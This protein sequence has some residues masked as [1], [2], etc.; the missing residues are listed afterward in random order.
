MGAPPSGTAWRGPPVEQGD[1]EAEAPFRDAVAE[2]LSDPEVLK[3]M[4]FHHLALAFG[5]GVDA[6]AGRWQRVA[7]AD[8]V[9]ETLSERDLTLRWD[10]VDY[11]NRKIDE[12]RGRLGD[13]AFQEARARGAALTDEEITAFLPEAPV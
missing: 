10:L 9:S 8:G 13:D 12:A 5:A 3:A 2:M 6:A 7:T 4:T 11:F 1:L